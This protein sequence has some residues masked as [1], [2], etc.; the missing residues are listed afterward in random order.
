[1]Q[2]YT[3][4]IFVFTGCAQKMLSNSILHAYIPKMSYLGHF[5]SFWGI[6]GVKLC[7]NYAPKN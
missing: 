6:L 2:P 1:M 3:T 4:R 7:I 5:G